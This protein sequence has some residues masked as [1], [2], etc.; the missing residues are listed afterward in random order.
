MYRTY[1]HPLPWIDKVDWLWPAGDKKLVQVFDHVSDI[2]L[3]MRHVDKRGVC[4]QAG[5]ACGIWPLR[6]SQL[7]GQVHTF[8]PQ[9]DNYLCLLNNTESADN[10]TVYHAPL[11]NDHRRYTVQND[12]QERE[13][14]GAGYVVENDNGI[15]SLRID[16]IRLAGCDLIQLDVEGFEL[17]ALQGGAETISAYRPVIVLE[18][19][20]LSHVGTDPAMARKWLAAEFGY[21][22]VDSIHRDVVLAC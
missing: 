3:F 15:K 14:C 7:F 21:K 12:M 19:K 13:N 2:D 5:G 22:L 16:D 4:V 10:I 9:D 1:T 6:F 11:S 20:R 18:E 8:E 17:Q